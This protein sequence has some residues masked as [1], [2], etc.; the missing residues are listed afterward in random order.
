MYYIVSLRP[1]TYLRSRERSGDISKITNDDR[2][3]PLEV[4][5]R[6]FYTIDVYF[7]VQIGDGETTEEFWYK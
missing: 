4:E 2:N 1:V 3:I 6:I 5:E 7:Y